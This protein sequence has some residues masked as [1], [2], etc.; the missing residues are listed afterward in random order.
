MPIILSGLDVT[1]AICVIDIDDVLVARM[2]SFEET[3]SNCLKIFNFK[4]TF[5]VAASTTKSTA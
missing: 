5:S 4:L 3:S 2:V 1:D